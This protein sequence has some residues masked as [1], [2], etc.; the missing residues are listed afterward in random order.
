[1]AHTT[2]DVNFAFTPRVE[3]IRNFE[4]SRPKFRK[5]QGDNRAEFEM[6]CTKYNIF[7]YHL[8]PLIARTILTENVKMS[9]DTIIPNVFSYT[10]QRFVRLVKREVSRKHKT[11]NIVSLNLLKVLG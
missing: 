3:A 5:T 8:T 10:I 7:A 4:F 1:M 6:W 2:S 11:K 9:D